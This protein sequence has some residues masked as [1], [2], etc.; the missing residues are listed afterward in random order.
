MDQKTILL[1][2]DNADDEALTLRAFETNIAGEVMVTRDGAERW[3]IC[4]LKGA[5]SG[6]EAHDP[7]VVLLD[8]AA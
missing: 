2:E 5:T 1:V 8:L 7:T 3:N 6:V 4:L